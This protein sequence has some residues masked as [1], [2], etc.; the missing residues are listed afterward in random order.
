MIDELHN[1]LPQKIQ[2]KKGNITPT[3]ES[4]KKIDNEITLLKKNLEDNLDSIDNKEIKQKADNVINKINHDLDECRYKMERK[5]LDLE[6]KKRELD[7]LEKQN[8][9]D[10]SNKKNDLLSSNIQIYKLDNN[11]KYLEKRREELL[12]IQQIASQVN[13]LTKDMNQTVE[14]QGE[15]IN[16]I[17]DNIE[18]MEKNVEEGHKNIKEI[19]KAQK[20]NRKRLCCIFFMILFVIIVIILILFSLLKD[21]NK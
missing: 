11:S 7:A 14:K 4:Y 5:I 12:N 20:A 9:Y 6:S 2:E 13:S 16:S 17:E 3:I 21:K 1:L 15:Q 18:E 8:N 10:N 19:A